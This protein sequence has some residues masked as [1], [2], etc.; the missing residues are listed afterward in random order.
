MPEEPTYNASLIDGDV[1]D[2]YVEPSP[3]QDKTKVNLTWKTV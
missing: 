1:F 2:I 3:Y